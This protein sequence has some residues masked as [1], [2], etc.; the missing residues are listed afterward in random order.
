MG[1]GRG[2]GGLGPTLDFELFSKKSCFLS[3]E[4]E[5]SNFAT[6]EPLEKFWKNTLVA[7][8]CKKS[9]RRPWKGLD[10]I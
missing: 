7:P 10:F 4:W 3:F 5:K 1:V 2:A 8:P 9:F 6:F